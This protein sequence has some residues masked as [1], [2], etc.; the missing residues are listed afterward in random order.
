MEVK[1][2]VVVITGAARGLGRECALRFGERG[3]KVAAFDVDW[4]GLSSLKEEMDGNGN[5]SLVRVV[6][7]TDEESVMSAFEA[8]VET[9][10]RVDVLV[11]NAGITG[12]HLLVRR[13]EGDVRKFPL[14]LW[15]RVISVNL[16]GVFL[17]GREAAYWMTEKGNKGVIVNISSISRHGNIGQS[18]Y[19][20]TKAGVVALTVTWAKEL[21]PYGIRVAAVA[22]GFI[23]TPM[24]RA[25]PEKVLE[26]VV[27]QIP[28]GRLGKPEE[29]ASTVLF[30]VEN[31]YVNGRVI[32]VDG[33]LRL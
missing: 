11:N 27:S 8:V 1:D 12:D 24:A 30:I 25:V 4:E 6:D 14:D 2:R 10:G 32:E 7:V 5:S 31:D 9:F 21:A 20:A 18:S 3:A 22:P 13:K 28:A 33:G 26:K 16:T 23:D 17:C 15:N 19:S 29:I